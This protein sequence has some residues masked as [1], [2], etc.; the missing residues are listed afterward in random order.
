MRI[1]TQYKREKPDTISG[2]KI[3]IIQ[4]YS[5]FNKEEIDKLEQDCKERIGFGLVAEVKGEQE[6]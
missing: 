2:E 5:S 6:C 3:S 1:L 4:T